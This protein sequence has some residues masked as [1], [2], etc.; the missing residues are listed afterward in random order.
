MRFW[1]GVA[2]C[3]VLLSCSGDRPSGANTLPRLEL[4]AHSGRWVVLNY[5]AKWC[6][7]CIEE[8]PEL[9]ALNARYEQVQVLG[10]NYDGASGAELQQQIA[11]L[12]IAFPVVLEE[13]SSALQFSLPRVLPSTLIFN[14]EGE[15]VHTLLGPQTLE[16]LELAT[17]QTAPPP[18]GD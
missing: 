17:E 12:G 13:P 6:K 1:I 5:W 16:S 9:N 18:A 10:V 15:L 4:S 14:P 7:P 3:S 8:I 2:L 11:A